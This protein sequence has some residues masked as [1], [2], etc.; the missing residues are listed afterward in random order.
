MRQPGV[1]RAR[2]PPRAARRSRAASCPRCP[3]RERAPFGALRLGPPRR[4]V[5]RPRGATRGED[6]PQ[7]AQLVDPDLW[8]TGAQMSSSRRGLTGTAT[9][10]AD[11]GRRV[12]PGP[13]GKGKP[14]DAEMRSVPG[15]GSGWGS[16]GN[17]HLG[18][19]GWQIG[20]GRRRL[21]LRVGFRLAAAAVVV[22]APEERLDQ[23]HRERED[24][25]RCSAEP[26]SAA[27][28]GN[29]AAVRSDAG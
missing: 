6:R 12:Q 22:G 11:Q 23:I 4:E 24:R 15:A 10:Q 8:R 25:P 21:G 1:S 27:S 2:S 13:G 3:R 26:T 28:A 20:L 16:P 7:P 14:E 18:A 9:G 17:S 5:V 19:G 29:A